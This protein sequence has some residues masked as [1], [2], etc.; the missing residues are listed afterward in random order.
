MF[1]DFFKFS[2]KRKIVSKFLK[3]EDILRS[4]NS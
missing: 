2:R 1:L 4:Q 3:S